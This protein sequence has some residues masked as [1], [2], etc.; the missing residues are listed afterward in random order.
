MSRQCQAYQT[1]LP[2]KL[3]AS[4]LSEIVSD[5]SSL[6]HRTIGQPRGAYPAAEILT[7]LI[8]L[9]DRLGAWVSTIPPEFA[10]WSVPCEEPSGN[11]FGSYFDVY[12][13]GEAAT[14]LNSFRCVRAMV[15]D[16]ILKG[17]N[18][19]S[20]PSPALEYRRDISAALVRDACNDVCATVPYL[21]DS[22]RSANDTGITPTI[23]TGNTVMWA[24]CVVADGSYTSVPGLSA[25]CCTQLH[26]IWETTGIQQAKS[27]A[28]L[29]ERGIDIRQWA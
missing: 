6:R 5:L 21:V 17:I 24:L 26:R 7:T 29:I 12:D 16:Y 1:H 3:A 8:D 2:L 15:N 20:S 18:S 11:V 19:T 9:D 10:K 13:N 25:W 23:A 22:R 4:K 28:E 14:I 27:M